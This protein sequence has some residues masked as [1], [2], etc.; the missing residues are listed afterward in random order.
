VARSRSSTWARPMHDPNTLPVG[1]TLTKQSHLF[2][3]VGGYVSFGLQA[4]FCSDVSEFLRVHVAPVRGE[5]PQGCKAVFGK[6]GLRH[7]SAHPDLHQAAVNHGLQWRWDF[8]LSGVRTT[9]P[10]SKL[11]P[12][13][14][15]GRVPK[16][17][18]SSRRMYSRS[19]GV[20]GQ[21]V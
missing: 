18:S 6:E 15:D 4:E 13:A 10:G 3:R 5:E 7:R 21:G 17:M 1:G 14:T 11:E 9:T 19:F 20:N 2:R 12:S 8:R 16:K